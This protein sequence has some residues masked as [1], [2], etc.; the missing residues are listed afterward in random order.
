MYLLS[1]IDLNRVNIEELRGYIYHYNV[2]Q[3]AYMINT[4]I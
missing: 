4:N 3:G 2:N 1:T